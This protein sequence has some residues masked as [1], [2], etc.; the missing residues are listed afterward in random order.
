MIAR[1]LVALALALLVAGS[2][3]VPCSSAAVARA[4]GS[5]PAHDP[6]ASHANAD[7]AEDA[8]GAHGAGDC[9]GPDRS[10]GPQ[11]PC[12][13]TGDGPGAAASTASAHWALPAPVLARVDVG[14][15]AWNGAGTGAHATRIPA[16]VDH[17]PIAS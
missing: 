7:H 10:I 11:C 12:G 13:C 5:A 17:V 3:V 6:H 1:R 8:Q 9:H 2:G 14:R 16:G 15:S 4:G